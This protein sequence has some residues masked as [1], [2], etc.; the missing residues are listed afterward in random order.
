MLS[1]GTGP[2]LLLRTIFVLGLIVFLQ[3]QRTAAIRRGCLV[4]LVVVVAHV[5]GGKKKQKTTTTGRRRG[6]RSIRSRRRRRRRR[7]RRASVSLS[8]E[9][10]RPVYGE[11]FRWTDAHIFG[12][13]STSLGAVP[14][15]V[16]EYSDA[17]LTRSPPLSSFFFFSS[18]KQERTSV[19]IVR[20]VCEHIFL[21]FSFSFSRLQ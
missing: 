13:F 15:S 14:C 9:Q 8:K 1:N 18:L 16:W 3:V 12:W 7:S 19:V 17:F 4:V 2:P 6:S 10:V 21:L 20:V 11:V 5:A